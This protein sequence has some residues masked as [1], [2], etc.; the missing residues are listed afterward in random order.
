VR[1]SLL[2]GLVGAHAFQ[3][4]RWTVAREVP[5]PSGNHHPQ[6]APYGT[7]RC[8]DGALQLAVGNEAIWARFAPVVDID[9]R[10]P[11]FVD[12]ARRFAHREELVEV[13][14]KAFAG[15]TRDECLADL[16]EAGVPSGAIRTLD[17]VYEWDQT[18]SQGLVI[19][20]DHPVVGPIALPG[21]TLRLEGLDGSPRG[22]LRHDA[23]PLLDQH[24][25]SV[26]EW[27]GA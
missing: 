20:V 17:E 6:I 16:A 5:R 8:A 11:R 19:E 9:A 15:R 22:R 2:A 12:N 26:R 14:E 1:T 23:P 27:A 3:G 24:A 7:F 4:T 18:R 13:I 25:E 10:D 21:P